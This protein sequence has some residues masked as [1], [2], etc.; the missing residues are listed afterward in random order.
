MNRDFIFGGSI[1][2]RGDFSI[3]FETSICMSIGPEFCF[4]FL[5]DFF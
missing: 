1:F 2:T 3:L 4:I 5:S